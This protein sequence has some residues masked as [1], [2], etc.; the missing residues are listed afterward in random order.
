MDSAWFT[1]RWPNLVDSICVGCAGAGRQVAGSDELFNCA[2]T[3]DGT[4]P[5]VGA[6][7]TSPHQQIPPPATSDYYRTTRA[8]STHPRVYK[9]AGTGA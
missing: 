4:S 8:V 7:P 3:E 5:N 9:R 1:V 6:C 2:K